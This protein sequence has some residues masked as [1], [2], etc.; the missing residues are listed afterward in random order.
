[1]TNPTAIQIDLVKLYKPEFFLSG[2]L[3][4]YFFYVNKLFFFGGN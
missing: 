1:M 3:Y 2:T 4:Y